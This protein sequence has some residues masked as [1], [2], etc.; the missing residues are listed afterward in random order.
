M[1]LMI[2]ADQMVH[3]EINH[4]LAQVNKNLDL[5]AQ[6]QQMYEDQGQDIVKEKKEESKQEKDS[7]TQDR[8][9]KKSKF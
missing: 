5:N 8:E 6:K 9:E 3:T 2:R 1:F 4:F 7:Q